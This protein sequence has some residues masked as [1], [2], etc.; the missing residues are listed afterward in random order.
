[1]LTPSPQH[2]IFKSKGITIEHS[3]GSDGADGGG[4]GNGCLKVKANLSDFTALGA[5]SD[6]DLQRLLNRQRRA[7]KATHPPGSWGEWI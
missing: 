6:N 7:R 5:L 3:V 2:Q 1:M 4:D